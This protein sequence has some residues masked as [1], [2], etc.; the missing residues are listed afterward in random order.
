MLCATHISQHP[1]TR[2]QSELHTDLNSAWL[3]NWLPH[4]MSVWPFH[5]WRAYN[6]ALKIKLSHVRTPTPPTAPH[7]QTHTYKHTNKNQIPGTV[8]PPPP[9]PP[10]HLC[11]HLKRAHDNQ[12]SS[13]MHCQGFWQRGHPVLRICT[14]LLW[15]TC[16][17]QANWNL[18]LCNDINK[19]PT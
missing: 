9:P 12:C 17:V 6:H 11:L 5:T 1:A 13:H 15:L 19:V 14:H 18:T 3:P 4:C 16:S 2:W 7:R 8:S 10:L